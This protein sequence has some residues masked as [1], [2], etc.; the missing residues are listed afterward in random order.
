MG[1]WSKLVGIFTGGEASSSGGATSAGEPASGGAEAAAS[2]NGNPERYCL[3]CH[4]VTP[5]SV[6]EAGSGETVFT[7]S[8]C[9]QSTKVLM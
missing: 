1:F 3:T 6:D 7:C 4:K 9:E 2:G 8:F 5:G